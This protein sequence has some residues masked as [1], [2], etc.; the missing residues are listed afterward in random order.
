[1]EVYCGVCGR[2]GP[3]R[4]FRLH[5]VCPDS[6]ESYICRDEAACDRRFHKNLDRLVKEGKLKP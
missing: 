2:K 5:N 1:M 6:E 4:E 3:K